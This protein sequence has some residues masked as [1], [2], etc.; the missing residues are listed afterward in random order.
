MED[1]QASVVTCKCVWAIIVRVGGVPGKRRAADKWGWGRE[2]IL[3]TRRGPP[4]AYPCCSSLCNLKT[5]QK[6]RFLPLQVTHQC[7]CLSEMIW[8]D[9]LL[10]IVLIASEAKLCRSW[11]RIVVIFCLECEMIL[12]SVTK[13]RVEAEMNLSTITKNMV[14]CKMILSSVIK[15]MV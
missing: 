10:V 7:T 14:E 6:V 11:M 2:G 15:N 1:W 13:I 9:R 8:Y 4:T 5:K 3:I 12:S